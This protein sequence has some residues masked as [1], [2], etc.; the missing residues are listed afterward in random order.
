MHEGVIR[1]RD[2]SFAHSDHADVEFY[3]DQ[4]APAHWEASTPG[5]PPQH[6]VGT[7][8]LR[9][10]SLHMLPTLI[11]KVRAAIAPELKQCA[12]APPK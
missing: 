10:Y 8:T 1:C 4:K 7:R 6:V 12:K 2:E 9:K 5:K 11:A 3:T